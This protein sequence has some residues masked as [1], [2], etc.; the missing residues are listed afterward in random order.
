ML[1]AHEQVMRDGM[2]W[3]AKAGPDYFTGGLAAMPSLHMAHALVMTWFMIKARSI[4]VPAFLLIT[5]WVLI[6]SVASRWHYIIDLPAGAL[7]AV[8]VIWLTNR[9][10]ASAASCGRNE[11][12]S[13]G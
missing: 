5:F 2:A 12:P 6:E 8:F 11:E 13:Q 3:I 10:C 9:F 4:W 7:L 1:W